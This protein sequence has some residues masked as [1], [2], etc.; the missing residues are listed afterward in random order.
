MYSHQE[1]TFQDHKESALPAKAWTLGLLCTVWVLTG[2]IGHDPWKSIDAYGF[3]LVYH[4]IQS[5]DWLVPTLAGRPDMDNPPLFYM[6]AAVLANLFAPLLPLHDGARLASGLYT[7]IT[8][9]FV[10]LTGRKLFGTGRGW[11]AV[12]ILIGCLG[13]LVHVH[14]LFSELALLAGC[15]MMLYGYAKSLHSP[16]IAGLAIGCGVGIGFMSND[17]TAL[18][19]FLGVSTTLLIFSPWR[20]RSYFS[21]LGIA[22]IVTLPW[23]LIWPFLLYVRSPELF[24]VWAWDANIGRWLDF[25]RRGDFPALLHYLKAL[26]WFAWPALPLAAWAVW[27]AR[28]KIMQETAFQLPLVAFVVILLALNFSPNYGE[29]H[30]MPLLLPLALLACAALSTLR[31]GAANAL[32]WFGIMTFGLLTILLWWAWAGLLLNNR[33]RVTTLLKEYHPSFMPSV[34]TPAFWI[35]IIFTVLWVIMVWRVRRSMRRAV[36]NWAAGVTLIW[37]LVMTIWLPW[38]DTGKS[39]R[40]LFISLKQSLPAQHRCVASQN[41]GDTQRVLLQYFS[42]IN[43]LNQAKNQCDL[44]LLQGEPLLASRNGA[45]WIKLWEDKRLGARPEYYYLYQRS[46]QAALKN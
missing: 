25:M 41:I 40:S 31:R 14:E 33:T 44:L 23:L 7:S 26:A 19:L 13:L 43:T 45:G 28:F 46:K 24:M 15:A 37:V 29:E 3:A 10:G 21:S 36:V 32:N 27:Q 2:L 35:G 16:L 4:I 20:T 18:V 11:A 30:A 1:F 6:T 9:I 17:F 8:L 38:L 34:E 12:I 42:R 39:Y 5:G 22:L